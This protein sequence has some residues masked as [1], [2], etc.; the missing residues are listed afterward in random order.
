MHDSL[1]THLIIMD[2]ALRTRITSLV[3]KRLA[4]AGNVTPTE[5]EVFD[6]PPVDALAVAV[7]TN[8]TIFTAVKNALDP[9][10]PDVP[11]A[12]DTVPDSDLDYVI[13]TALPS[14]G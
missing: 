14:L 8:P 11:R 6:P 12:I 3:R 5:A 4:V 9:A 13:V 7:A 2:T 1:L 10:A